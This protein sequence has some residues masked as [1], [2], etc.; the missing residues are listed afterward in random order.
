[1]LRAR[2]SHTETFITTPGPPLMER[3]TQINH[4]L[5]DRKWH[6][7]IL[8]VRSFRGADC[9]TDHYLVVAKFRE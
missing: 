4:I 2:C 1:M 7:F 5:R 9:D 8:D 6:L 3:L